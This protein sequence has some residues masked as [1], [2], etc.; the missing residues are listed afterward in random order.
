MEIGAVEVASLGE[1]AP[2][3]DADRTRVRPFDQP[4]SLERSDRAVHMDGGEPGCVGK[5]FLGDRQLVL[6]VVSQ[7]RQLEPQ[8]ELAS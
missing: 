8:G 7:P 2:L 4:V 5:L 3:T 6:V 1:L